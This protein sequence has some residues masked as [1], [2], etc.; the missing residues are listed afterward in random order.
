MISQKVEKNSLIIILLILFGVGFGLYLRKPFFGFEKSTKS[1]MVVTGPLVD[2]KVTQEPSVKAEGSFSLD[3]NKNLQGNRGY[4]N[5]AALS[6]KKIE[7]SQQDQKKWKLIEEFLVSK[8]D[9]DPRVDQE[10]S[11]ISDEL[12]LKIENAYQ[13]LPLEN[14]NGRGFLAFLITR[15]LRTDK[16]V[17]FLK[18][19]FEEKACLSLS[20]CGS[21]AQEDPH[22]D[23]VNN[24]SLNYPQMTALYQLQKRI[25]N[26][27]S[28]LAQPSVRQ[29]IE[30]LLREAKQFPAPG[31]SSRVEEIENLLRK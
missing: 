26:D 17:Q 9:N 23:S 4:E 1:N 19:I 6:D 12:K 28:I 3:Q 18:S 10:L 21:S 27:P 22:L 11:S 7:L 25:E 20:D 2:T 5:T 13:A 16:D 8:D 15:D 24:V 31:I 14:R 29:E 30:L